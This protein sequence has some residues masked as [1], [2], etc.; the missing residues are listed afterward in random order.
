[1]IGVILIQ[2]VLGVKATIHAL[3]LL[4][5]ELLVQNGIILLIRVLIRV[6]LQLVKILVWTTVTATGAAPQ[7]LASIMVAKRAILFPV[8]IILFVVD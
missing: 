3:I 8:T 5:K 7:N 1:V 2:I 6:P 4:T